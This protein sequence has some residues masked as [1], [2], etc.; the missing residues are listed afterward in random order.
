MDRLLTV[1]EL[2]ERLRVT[3]TCIYR[4]LG[5]EDFLPAIRL[6]K[7]CVRFRESDV[8]RLL[9][10]WASTALDPQQ[11]EAGQQQFVRTN[12]A[13]HKSGRS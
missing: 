9:D 13:G 2:A 6:S 12:H 1:R 7:R 11:Q 10:T 5:K 4:W 8:Q 3:P